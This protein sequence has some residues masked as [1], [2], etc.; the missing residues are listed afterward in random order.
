MKIRRIVGAVVYT[1]DE[2]FLM[3]SPKWGDYWMVPGGGIEKYET[4]EE[5]LRREIREELG[6]EITNLHRLG[7]G[8]KPPSD[9]FYDSEMEF[10]YADYCAKAL[11][12][13]VKPNEEISEW[14]WFTLEDAMKLNLLD[15]TRN[16]LERYLKFRK[17]L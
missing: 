13:D 12:T 16:L 14:G 5:A 9:D 6:I 11:S 15:I 1:D 8:V 3:K 17:D 2:I 10:H 4:E 7:E